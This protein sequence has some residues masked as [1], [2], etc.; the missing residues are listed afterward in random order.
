MA[1]KTKNTA[2]AEALPEPSKD[3]LEALRGP[4]DELG[5]Q[6]LFTAIFFRAQALGMDE[7]TED[8]CARVV[9]R[10]KTFDVSTAKH[11][12]LEKAF[13]LAAAGEFERSGIIFRDDMTE[14][15]KL[16]KLENV[17]QRYVPAGI[18]KL[19]QAREFGKR[20]AKVKRQ[21]GQKNREA[22]L[23]AAKD[24]LKKRKNPKRP[25]VRQLALLIVKQT[26]LSDSTVRHVLTK[27]EL[28]KLW[29]SRAR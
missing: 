5:A 12:A 16:K 6:L 27:A 10:V 2:S 22:V 7:V 18:R 17:A 19:E 8:F 28:D 25:S 3:L 20:G 9:E 11:T 24:I 29:Q 15:G 1:G 13:H 14:G 23:G 26:D 21:Q 4:D